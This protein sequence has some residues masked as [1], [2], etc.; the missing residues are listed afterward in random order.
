MDDV[1]YQIAKYK[2]N[3]PIH[4]RETTILERIKRS[5]FIST[6]PLSSG[7][8]IDYHIDLYNLELKQVTAK[9]SEELMVKLVVIVDGFVVM[10]RLR[11]VRKKSKYIIG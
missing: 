6:Q 8:T 3:S 2:N 11:S 4:A 10:V 7:I 9:L 1:K 5:G